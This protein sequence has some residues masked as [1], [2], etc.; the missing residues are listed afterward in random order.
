M[1]K[2][3]V[4]IRTYESGR[5]IVEHNDETSEARVCKRMDGSTGLALE[6]NVQ[7]FGTSLIDHQAELETATLSAIGK[8]GYD[9]T[10]I[11]GEDVDNSTAMD[12]YETH[13]K[14]VEDM[15]TLGGKTY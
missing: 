9:V 13:H 1:S 8:I 6:G 10:L 15:M 5:T 4:R 3:V 2:Q 11:Y 14:A 12:A 7:F